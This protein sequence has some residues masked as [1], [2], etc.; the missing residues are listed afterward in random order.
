MRIFFRNRSKL[1]PPLTRCPC[2]AVS[3]RTPNAAFRSTPTPQA[4]QQSRRA[5]PQK[6]FKT[7]PGLQEP[8]ALVSKTR[9][10]LRCDVPLRRKCRLKKERRKDRNT[11][12]HQSAQAGRQRAKSD[13]FHNTS[14]VLSRIPPPT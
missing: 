11:P 5:Q 12:S 13:L 14:G 3:D 4:F 7:G 2:L 10:H 8:S 1:F 6:G 9:R